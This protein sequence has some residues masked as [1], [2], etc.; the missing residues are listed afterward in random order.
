M[1]L[2]IAVREGIE[3]SRRDSTKG[4]FAAAC[5]QPI[6]FIYFYIC[7]HETSGSVCHKQRV[8]YLI[9]PPYNVRRVRDSNPRYRFQYDGFQDRS[10][11]PL[12]QLSC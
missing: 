2:G 3:P 1:Y 6:P 8:C 7:T 11:Q 12:W 10:I 4:T 9:S 5:G